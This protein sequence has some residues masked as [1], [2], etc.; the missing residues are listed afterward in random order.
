M[1]S[2]PS[3]SIILSLVAFISIRISRHQNRSADCCFRCFCKNHT[4]KQSDHDISIFN[5][6]AY[7]NE[8]SDGIHVPCDLKIPSNP[9]EWL[10][11]DKFYRGR[12]FFV[13]NP[14]SV[15]LSNFRNL[16][17]GLSIPNLWYLF[18]F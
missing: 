1:G 10:D 14:L 4:S 15:M 11:K 5:M 7:L 8:L 18:S 13:E 3:Q 9:P 2:G 17:I 12:R 16:V 6:T